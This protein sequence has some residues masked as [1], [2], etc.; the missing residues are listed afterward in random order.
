MYTWILQ[1]WEAFDCSLVLGA[2]SETDPGI[3]E[4]CLRPSSS[5]NDRVDGYKDFWSQKS[6]FSPPQCLAIAHSWCGTG[7]KV[8]SYFEEG[9]LFCDILSQLHSVRGLLFP[10]I[11]CKSTCYNPFWGRGRSKES[12]KAVIEGL[13]QSLSLPSLLSAEWSDE[14]AQ[15]QAVVGLPWVGPGQGAAFCRRSFFRLRN[16]HSDLL[17]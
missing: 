9:Q 5:K 10:H 4:L 13:P 17:F 7:R 15:A 3:E 2:E 11:T 12:S 14:P 16:P 6:K 1:V 8:S